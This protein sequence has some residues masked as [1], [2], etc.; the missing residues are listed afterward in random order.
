MTTASNPTVA[1]AVSKSQSAPFSADAAAASGAPA[2]GNGQVSPVPRTTAEVSDIAEKMPARPAQAV[3]IPVAKRT[4]SAPQEQ[5]LSSNPPKT[6][7]PKPHSPKISLKPPSSNRPPSPL[8]PDDSSPCAS[9]SSC[10]DDIGSA[11]TG[12][13]AVSERSSGLRAQS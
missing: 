1:L 13:A 11:N 8:A 12:A 2:A 5:A 10:D 7:P 3:M 9:D 6:E 4:R